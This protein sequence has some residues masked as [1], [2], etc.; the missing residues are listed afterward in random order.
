MFPICGSMLKKF[1]LRS[2]AAKTTLFYKDN[3][4]ESENLSSLIGPSLPDGQK[5]DSTKD[6]PFIGI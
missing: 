2:V 3:D 6:A 4:T 5:T 1:T